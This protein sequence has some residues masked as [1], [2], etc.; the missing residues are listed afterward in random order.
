MP[1]TEEEGD[2]EGCPHLRAGQIG[3]G[4]GRGPGLVLSAPAPA[5]GT[6]WPR[7]GKEAAMSRS[8]GLPPLAGNAAT[9]LAP[10]AS[11]AT[12]PG[13]GAVSPAVR[14]QLLATRALEPA[15]HADHGPE[16]GPDPDHH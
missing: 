7:S 10:P 2:Q 4:F 3:D 16:R 11:D 5:A 8:P 1:T 12:Q 9:S 6:G 15:L 13:V 14:A